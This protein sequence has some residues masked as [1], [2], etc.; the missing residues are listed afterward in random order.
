[1]KATKDNIINYLSNLKSELQSEGIEKVGLFGSFAKNKADIHSDI[2]I[3]ISLK[4]NYLQTHDVWEYFNLIDNIKKLML[5][6]F[7]RK[8]DVFDLDSSTKIKNTILKETIYV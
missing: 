2:D 5:D 7:K 4:D 3:T 1:M 6:K 8:S